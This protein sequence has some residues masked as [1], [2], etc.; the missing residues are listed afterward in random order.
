MCA[1]EIGAVIQFHNLY[2]ASAQ[3]QIMVVLVFSLN[4]SLYVLY[5]YVCIC[6]SLLLSLGLGWTMHE[7][8]G[9][10]T[11]IWREGAN[12]VIHGPS[13]WRATVPWL[14]SRFLPWGCLRCMTRA[15]FVCMYPS[16]CAGRDGY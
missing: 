9:P 3:I 10:G 15:S 1:C 12:I 16:A 7:Q 4:L 11:K 6:F 8:A 13:K 5:T 2:L 14:H